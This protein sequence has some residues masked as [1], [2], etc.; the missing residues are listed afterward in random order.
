VP[1]PGDLSEQYPE[2]RGEL[3]DLVGQQVVQDL[4][5]A[6]RIQP[7]ARL[8]ALQREFEQGAASPGAA[9]RA[10]AQNLVDGRRAPRGWR[11]NAGHWAPLLVMLCLA[12]GT[13]AVGASFGLHAWQPD[14]ASPAQTRAEVSATVRPSGVALPSVVTVPG[15]GEDVAADPASGRA[16]VLD[17]ATRT[18]R[19]V[20]AL[21]GK[22][23]G[24]MQTR[25]NPDAL[26]VDTVRHR[27]YVAVGDANAPAGI[28][29]Q[30][31]GEGDNRPRGDV[32]LGTGDTPSASVLGMTVVPSTGT[33]LVT[34]TDGSMWALNPTSGSLRQIWQ[35]NT[36][37]QGANFFP[38]AV[39][40]S[41]PSHQIFAV[42]HNNAC[43]VVLDA[44][45]YRMQRVVPVGNQP[46][47]LAVDEQAGRVFVASAGDST[48]SMLDLKSDRVLRT[49]GVGANPHGVAVDTTTGH[50][51]VA[52]LQG[53]TV[54]VYDAES[55]TV[56]ATISVPVRPD[57]LAVNGTA[58]LIV[59]GGT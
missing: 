20:N 9:W 11:P 22:L 32:A 57:A 2:L 18:V 10:E 8:T 50:V 7:P 36:G 33:V 27:L 45:T 26:A 17:G 39:A 54:G 28:A 42:D 47:G 23:I 46:M 15:V 55:G 51:F 4:D 31:F 44:R 38:I 19:A 13:V 59:V 29:I 30:M 12:A 34:E 41:E 6:Y 3:A 52:N 43:V 25:G 37:C 58:A 49:F 35:E 48:V 1:D 53:R 5:R 14:H 40:V 21:T 56:L 24:R 16:Y